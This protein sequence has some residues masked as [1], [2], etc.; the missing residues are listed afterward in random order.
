M[1]IP[2]SQEDDYIF[3]FVIELSGIITGGMGLLFEMDRPHVSEVC[4]AGVSTCGPGLCYVEA[5]QT[6]CQISQISPVISPT[7]MIC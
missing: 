3:V 4:D 1:W 7:L 6:T 2:V 5:T